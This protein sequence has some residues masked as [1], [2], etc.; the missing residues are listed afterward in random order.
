LQKISTNISQLCCFL[1]CPKSQEYLKYLNV[2]EIMV[3]QPGAEHLNI[4][5]KKFKA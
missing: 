2:N 3:K 5:R 1:K 4:C